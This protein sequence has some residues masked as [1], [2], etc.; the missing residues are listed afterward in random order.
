MTGDGAGDEVSSQELAP[1]QRAVKANSINGCER[2]QNDSF[3]ARSR[4]FSGTPKGF[5]RIRH[6]GFLANRSGVERIVRKMRKLGAIPQLAQSQAGSAKP[7]RVFVFSGSC[8]R[9]G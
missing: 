5:V 8:G 1:R 7:C 3:F 6:F 9:V 4:R 2:R